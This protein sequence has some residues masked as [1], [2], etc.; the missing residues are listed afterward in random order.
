MDFVVTVA[1]LSCNKDTGCFYFLSPIP[2]I[3]AFHFH[4][5]YHG[6]TL[7]TTRRKGKRRC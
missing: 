1:A 5:L 6:I 7:G 4:L 2:N 3:L